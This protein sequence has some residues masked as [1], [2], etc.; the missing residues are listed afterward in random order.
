VCGWRGAGMVVSLIM[1]MAGLP[2]WD[3]PAL[4]VDRCLSA[5]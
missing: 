1:V 2:R 5:W 4:F 3:L